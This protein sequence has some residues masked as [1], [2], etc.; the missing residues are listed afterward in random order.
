MR[1]VNVAVPRD[2]PRPTRVM[3]GAAGDLS[4]AP[5][6]R[7]LDP[8]GELERPRAQGADLGGGTRGAPG[9]RP[10]GLKQDVRGGRGHRHHALDPRG[11]QEVHGVG[12]G[13]A[14]IAP[15]GLPGERLPAGGCT[16]D[17]ALP[18]VR[19]ARMGYR[20]A[21]GVRG[22]GA[23]TRRGNGLRPWGES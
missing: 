14:P 3:L 23:A 15:V 4:P 1:V 7:A 2:S 11:V 13:K 8:G 17:A 22:S 10:Q 6:G 12:A 18:L 16:E 20:D 19:H 21:S 5:S 9:V